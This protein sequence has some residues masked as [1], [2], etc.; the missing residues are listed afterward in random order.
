M[1]N[2]GKKRNEEIKGTKEY[3]EENEKQR[4]CLYFSYFLSECQDHRGFI[5]G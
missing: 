1:Q 5:V 3:G 4:F 2:E